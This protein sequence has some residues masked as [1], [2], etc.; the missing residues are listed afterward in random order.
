M[1][2][3]LAEA[4]LLRFRC[5]GY[6]SASRA[7]IHVNLIRVRGHN[8]FGCPKHKVVRPIFGQ[9]KNRRIITQELSHLQMPS[10]FLLRG[11]I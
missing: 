9:L 3:V 1:P 2:V 10:R 8:S 6:F 4:A 5:L 11:Q 7:P